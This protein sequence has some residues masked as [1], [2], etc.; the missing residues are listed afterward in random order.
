[1]KINIKKILG[2]SVGVLSVATISVLSILYSKDEFVDFLKKATDE[3]LDSER[4]KVRLDF[5]NPDLDDDYRNS[6]QVKLR[7]F[8]S[9]MSK[10]AWKNEKPHAPS[11]H[12]ENGFYLPNDD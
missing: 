10:R 6:C 12:R 8:D 9:E 11:Y 5:C 7:A 1:M 2:I 4:E 3:E